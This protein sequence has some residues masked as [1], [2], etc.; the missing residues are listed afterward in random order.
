MVKFAWLHWH[1]Y[2]LRLQLVSNWRFSQRKLT[3]LTK[4]CTRHAASNKNSHGTRY[5]Q[6]PGNFY[7]FLANAAKFLMPRLHLTRTFLLL[8]LVY[9]DFVSSFASTFYQ[10]YYETYGIVAFKTYGNI[11][12]F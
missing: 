7:C 3:R 2:K 4:I 5:T 10:K 6:T 9:S 1:N 8:N 12:V 11:V